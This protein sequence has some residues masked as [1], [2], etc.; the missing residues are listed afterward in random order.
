ME[1]LCTPDF[2]DNIVILVDS[3]DEA[4]TYDPEENILTMLQDATD[5]PTD[6]PS[7]VP[8]ILTSRPDPRVL[9][10]IGKRY[11]DLIDDAPDDIDE[12]IM[13]TKDYVH[14]KIQYVLMI[15]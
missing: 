12:V 13:L 10:A 14:Y 4:L 8:F 5:H 9:N 3:L 7:Q 11:L 6:L 15:S 1:K 2:N